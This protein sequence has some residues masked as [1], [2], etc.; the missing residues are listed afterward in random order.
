M[1]KAKTKVPAINWFDEG[2]SSYATVSVA[3]KTLYLHVWKRKN[4][5]RPYALTVGETMSGG[6][7]MAYDSLAAVKG[8]AMAAAERFV[9]EGC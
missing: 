6:R 2:D 9:A 5:E 4:L 1:A 7:D 3:G 8:G